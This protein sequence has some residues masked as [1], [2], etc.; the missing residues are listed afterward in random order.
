M[1]SR[2][3]QCRAVNKARLGG[4]GDGGGGLGGKGGGRGGFGDCGG[5]GGGCRGAG[6]GGAGG[7]GG[8]A[9]MPGRRMSAHVGTAAG[10]RMCDDEWIVN[11][12]EPK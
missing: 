6:G 1:P 2:C 10:L 11:A 7:G 3:S 4:E 12:V 9:A 8:R 5:R